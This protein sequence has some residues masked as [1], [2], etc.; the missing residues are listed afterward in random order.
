MPRVSIYVSDAMKERM[1][2][3]AERVNWSEAAQRAFEQEIVAA[4]FKGENMEQVI[5]R[6][7]VSKAK[8]EKDQE[9]RGIEAG[10]KWAQNNAEYDKLRIIGNMTFE[11]YSDYYAG[12]VDFALGDDSQDWSNSFWNDH[13]GSPAP[14]DEFVE[15]FCKGASEVW[16]E[17]ADKL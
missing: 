7:R 8:Y 15:A 1:D 2:V 13:D 12:Q 10:R 11:P 14:T 16:E 3:L 9:M 5:E 4:T 17:V 6:L